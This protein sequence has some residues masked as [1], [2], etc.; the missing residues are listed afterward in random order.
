MKKYVNIGVLTLMLVAF[1]GIAF[2]EKMT[3]QHEVSQD[4]Q[5]NNSVTTNVVKKN[6]EN[7]LSS[8]RIKDKVDSSNTDLKGTANK[9]MTKYRQFNDGEG[10]I[11]TKK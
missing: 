11:K 1:S 7:K 8:K 4:K 9:Q 10:E 5:Q 3:V 6:K 2:A